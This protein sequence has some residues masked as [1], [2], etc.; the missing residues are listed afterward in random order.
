[1][2]QQAAIISG[3]EQ[4]LMLIQAFMQP[5]ATKQVETITFNV[6][7]KHEGIPFVI[8]VNSNTTGTFLVFRVIT[9]A[10]E[11][12]WQTWDSPEEVENS[13]RTFGLI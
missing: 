1:M 10:G 5:G 6:K 7:D 13:F 11:G 12:L 4:Q 2:T 8:E 3:N 9:T